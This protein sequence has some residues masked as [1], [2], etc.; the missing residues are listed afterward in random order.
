MGNAESKLQGCTNF[1][2]RQLVRRVSQRY[3]AEVGK[4]GLK[5][6][7]YSLLSHVLRLGP[8]RPGDLAAA[9]TM[10]ASTLTRNLKPMLAAGWLQMSAGADGRSRLVHI[11][12]AGRGK[13]AEAQRHWKAAQEGLNQL[14]GVERVRAIHALV[15]ES[16]VLLEPVSEGA[17]HE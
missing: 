12:D 3:D 2:L 6:T 5:T 1:K 7:Q 16:L 10:D 9:M 11:T 8:V 14:L 15:D 13:R 4:A 17:D